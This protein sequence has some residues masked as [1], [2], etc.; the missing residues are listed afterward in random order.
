MRTFF[1]LEKFDVLGHSW[2][3]L[4]VGPLGDW[5]WRSVMG[6]LDPQVTVIHGSHDPIPLDSA[7]EWASSIKGAKLAMIENS[8]HFPQI[9][10]PQ[11]FFAAVDKSLK[12][13]SG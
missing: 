1:K 6:K 7:L 10:Q 5:D 8:G 12:R 11:E 9:E 4:T 3:A 2:G 13:R